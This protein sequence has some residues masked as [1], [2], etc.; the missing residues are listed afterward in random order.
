MPNDKMDKDER[1]AKILE[2]LKASK[3]KRIDN[4]NLNNQLKELDNF[5]REYGSI[6]ALWKNVEKKKNDTKTKL[7]KAEK[8]LVDATLALNDVV[9]KLDEGDKKK[10]YR[11]LI[12]AAYGKGNEKHAEKF[13]EKFP[14]WSIAIG[15][16]LQGSSHHQRILQTSATTR[17]FK[18]IHRESNFELKRTG[19]GKI[20]GDGILSKI[21]SGW[22]SLKTAFSN[23]IKPDDIG[24]ASKSSLARRIKKFGEEI[25]RPWRMWWDFAAAGDAKLSKDDAKK[26]F[27]EK[28]KTNDPG[29]V[30]E[31]FNC[32]PSKSGGEHEYAI[33][34][35]E[36][37]DYTKCKGFSYMNM[38]VEDLDKNLLKDVAAVF[39]VNTKDIENN[40][41]NRDK[42]TASNIFQDK[43]RKPEDYEKFFSILEITDY[44]DNKNDDEI[45]TK[46]SELLKEIE[47]EEKLS[48]LAGTENA[49]I[50]KFLKSARI[51]YVIKNNKMKEKSEI[52][53]N[54][55]NIGN[56]LELSSAGAVD[57]KNLLN[58][59]DSDLGG[60]TKKIIDEIENNWDKEIAKKI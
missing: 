39:E 56:I 40:I 57:D 8:E 34:A 60:N 58:E 47:G 46:I 55:E 4:P 36:N 13:I 11:D 7:R 5:L 24:K 25:N 17:N 32:G 48:K 33:V 28:L 12:E 26:R 14:N 45:V 52:I 50:I 20:Q 15:L 53:A 51:S 27:K 29:E 42:I 38:V 19:K 37:N 9:G 18:D 49:N 41:A 10:S 30:A 59:K 31:F 2:E 43:D 21:K 54:L 3:Q 23:Y 6:E 22:K 35:N 1:R 44:Y 16:M